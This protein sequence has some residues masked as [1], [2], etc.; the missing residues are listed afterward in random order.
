METSGV[1]P[2]AQSNTARTEMRPIVARSSP[3]GTPG[4]P[5]RIGHRFER[6]YTYCDFASGKPG[7]R[8]LSAFA[9]CRDLP[10]AGSPHQQRKQ[11]HI[12]QP[13]LP[14]FALHG[15]Y[16]RGESPSSVKR[17][18]L[19]NP[20]IELLQA[21]QRISAALPRAY[22][23]PATLK[24]GRGGTIVLSPGCRFCRLVVASGKL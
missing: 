1:W 6:P 10:L 17:R 4:W 7:S 22:L 16:R 11:R 15:R 14:L 24:G 20:A 8:A 5:T 2:R 12:K 19:L 23:P 18:R 13:L 9:P 3:R 21:A